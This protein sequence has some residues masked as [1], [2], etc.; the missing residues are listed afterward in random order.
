MACHN[1]VPHLHRHG[2]STPAA[3][4]RPVRIGRSAPAA[5]LSG[6][7]AGRARAQRPVPVLWFTAPALFTASPSRANLRGRVNSPIVGSAACNN[8]SGRRRISL[9]M[10]RSGSMSLVLTGIVLLAFAVVAEP[11]AAPTCA[12]APVEG[13]HVRP[14]G[15]VAPSVVRARP[16][17]GYISPPYDIAEGRFR[18]HVGPFRDTATGLSQKIPWFVNHRAGTVK[19]LVIVGTRLTPRPRRTFRQV[20]RSNARTF[21]PTIISPPLPGCWRLQLS[22]GRA[23]GSLIARVDS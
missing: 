4:G 23:R 1:P 19:S 15:S 2:R 20:F 6:P 21:F 17:R 8:S 12:A 13:G 22:S 14:D 5:C 7:S 10:W 16:F 9:S 3:R 11:R 18:L